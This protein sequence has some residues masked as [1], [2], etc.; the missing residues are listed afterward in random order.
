MPCGGNDLWGRFDTGA[1]TLNA[2]AKCLKAVDTFRGANCPNWSD[3]V[4]FRNG[5]ANCPLR[6]GESGVTVEALAVILEPLGVSSR[7]VLQANQGGGETEDAEEA[8]L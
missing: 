1:C 8:G 5:T 6:S 4:H 7:G 3:D 2:N